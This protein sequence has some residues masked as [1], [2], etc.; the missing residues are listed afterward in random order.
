[1]TVSSPGLDTIFVLVVGG[2]TVGGTKIGSEWITKS[3]AKRDKAGFT[4]D[5]VI[6]RP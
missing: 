4:F 1:M 6:I 5:C 3:D 2:D